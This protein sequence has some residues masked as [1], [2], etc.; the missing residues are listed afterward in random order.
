MCN[1]RLCLIRVCASVHTSRP[2]N[3][4]MCVL[5]AFCVVRLCVYVRNS[6]LRVDAEFVCMHV[7]HSS[8]CFEYTCMLVFRV[9]AQFVWC[10][11][12]SCICVMIRVCV[13]MINAYTCV[14]VVRVCVCVLFVYVC[15]CVIRVCVCM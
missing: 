1:P 15:T 12:N 6:C 11:C 9:C 3:S 10:W 2:S 8:V 14:R 7:C 5:C 13:C 4:C